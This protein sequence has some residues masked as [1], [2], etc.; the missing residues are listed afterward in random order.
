[1]P[2]SEPIQLDAV[3]ADSRPNTMFVVEVTVGDKK[4]QVL[5]TV[6]GKMR[7]N[8]IRIFPGDKVIVEVSPYDLSRGRIVRLVRQPRMG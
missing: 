1:M 4:H 3:V 2:K 7:M 5:A 8:H 6:S